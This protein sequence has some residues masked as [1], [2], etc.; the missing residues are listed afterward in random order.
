VR[1]LIIEPGRLAALRDFA[2][3]HPLEWPEATRILAGEAPAAGDRLGYCIGLDLGFR[4]VYSVEDLPRATDPT[5][6]AGRFRR[7]SVSFVGDD[8]RI[9][10]P[11][12]VFEIAAELGFPA[13]GECSIE[14]ELPSRAVVLTAP[15]G[16]DAGDDDGGIS[17]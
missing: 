17:P 16:P 10:D 2:E 15:Y 8:A 7:M 14:V 6:C 9:P 1:V 11:L 12:V 3:S 5:V 13:V 4:L